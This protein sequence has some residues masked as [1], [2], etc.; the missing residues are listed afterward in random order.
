V[1]TAATRGRDAGPAFPPPRARDA[2]DRGGGRGQQCATM[3][4]GREQDAET[5]TLALPSVDYPQ[6]TTR[7]ASWTSAGA[8]RLL[9]FIPSPFRHTARR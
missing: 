4:S 8:V 9:R 2:R 7:S 6:A 1:T 3:P 5:P